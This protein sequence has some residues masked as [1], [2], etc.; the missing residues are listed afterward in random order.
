MLFLI[1][2]GHP[3]VVRVEAMELRFGICLHNVTKKTRKTNNS[4][5]NES[6][7]PISRFV[8]PS[9]CLLLR[10]NCTKWCNAWRQTHWQ[11]PYIT[12][13]LFI[14]TDSCFWSR[15]IVL[16][17]WRT[18]SSQRSSKKQKQ[19]LAEVASVN[20]LRNHISK[21]ILGGMLFVCGES[22]TDGSQHQDSNNNCIDNDLKTKIPSRFSRGNCLFDATLAMAITAHVAPECSPIV[23]FGVIELLERFY[24]IHVQDVKKQLNDQGM[25][26]GVRELTN[27]NMKRQGLLRVLTCIVIMAKYDSSCAKTTKVI[28]N[29]CVKLLATLF[30]AANKQL[31]LKSEVRVLSVSIIVFQVVCFIF[32]PPFNLHRQWSL[33]LSSRCLFQYCKSCRQSLTSTNQWFNQQSTPCVTSYVTCITWTEGTST[34]TSGKKSSTEKGAVF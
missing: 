15:P 32:S 12:A 33:R 28:I 26:P 21:E 20:C 27:L 1:F 6:S 19:H 24:P 17:L 29:N 23:K 10:D 16:S 9:S 30:P 3:I 11:E 34:A 22:E 7:S 4:S 2:L 31:L 14:S 5:R 13:S 25:S 18:M 8:F